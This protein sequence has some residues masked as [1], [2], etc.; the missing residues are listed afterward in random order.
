VAL[1]MF[2]LGSV[3]LPTMVLP[4]QVFESR[5]LELVRDCLADG[6]EPEFGVTMIERGFEVGGGDKRAMVGTVARILSVREMGPRLLLESVGTRRIRVMQ[7]LPDAPYPLAEVEDFHDTGDC[8]RWTPEA[9]AALATLR[10]LLAQAT[11]AGYDVAPFTTEFS[12]DPLVASYQASALVPAGP[13]D[14]Q[15]LLVASGPAERFALLAE[16]VRDQ[17]ELLGAI[18]AGDGNEGDGNDGDGNDGD[19]NDSG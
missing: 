7:W 19:V 4:L 2:P 9:R 15:R 5:Y 17:R 6:V 16:I 10:Q 18:L 8:D 11:E 12:D 14:H 13:F 3:L 1:P